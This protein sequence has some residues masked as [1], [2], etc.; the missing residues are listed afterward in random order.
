MRSKFAATAS[1]FEW[2]AIVKAH[3]AAQIER[4]DQAVGRD[5][6]ALSQVLATKSFVIGSR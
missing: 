3:I 2:L 5:F 1:A 6:P 4:I